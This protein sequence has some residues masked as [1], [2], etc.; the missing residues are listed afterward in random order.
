MIRWLYLIKY[1]E[2]VSVEDGEKWYLETHTQEAKRMVAQGLVSYKTWKALPA[3][4]GTT[5]RTKDQLNEW[6]RVTEL[7]FRSWDDFRAA[8]VEAGYEYTPPSY[9]A[10]GFV[11]QTVFLAEAAEYDLL[12]EI[13]HVEDALTKM[14]YP[15]K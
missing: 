1:P 3:P 7:V 14:E 15:A 9:G 6:H 12:A 5:S 8:V 13:P 10:K 11:Y 2:G 4:F